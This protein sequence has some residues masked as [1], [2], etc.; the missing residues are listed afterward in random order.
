MHERRKKRLE[1][2][3]NFLRKGNNPTFEALQEYLS[4]VDKRLKNALQIGYGILKCSQI[5]LKCTDLAVVQLCFFRE[6]QPN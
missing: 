3:I 1:A 4:E 6:V 5:V 2:F